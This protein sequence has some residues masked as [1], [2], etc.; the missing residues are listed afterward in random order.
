MATRQ[1]CDFRGRPNWHLTSRSRR[2]A[3]PPIHSSINKQGSLVRV[4]ATILAS[5]IVLAGCAGAPPTSSVIDPYII[6]PPVR[7]GDFYRQ[8]RVRFVDA[9]WNPVAAK[10][11]QHNVCFGQDEPELATNMRT[12]ISCG[13][14]TKGTNKIE[15]CTVPIADAALVSSISLV[16]SCLLTLHCSR[17]P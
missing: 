16:D 14:F 6:T 2:A 8:A 11:S 10:C 5:C 13:Y 3:P 9:G 1:R 17:R 4:S 12:G 15:I 7:I